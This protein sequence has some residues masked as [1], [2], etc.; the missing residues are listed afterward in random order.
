M[1]PHTEKRGGRPGPRP[2]GPFADKRKTLTTRITENTRLRL[3][4]AAAETGRSL[5]QEIELRLH[6]SFNTEQRVED[7]QRTIRETYHESFGGEQQFRIAKL[8]ANLINELE[9]TSEKSWRDDV[10]TNDEVV[11]IVTYFYRRYGPKRTREQELPLPSL[12]MAER[13]EYTRKQF[14]ILFAHGHKVPDAV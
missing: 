4:E 9:R 12:G 3:E 10:S 8:L 14:D 7:I 13:N 5:S 2:R 6:S 1:A 11:D